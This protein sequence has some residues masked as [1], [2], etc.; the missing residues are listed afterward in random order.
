M[1]RPGRSGGRGARAQRC[2]PRAT[3]RPRASYASRLVWGP[4][5]DRLEH[6]PGRRIGQPPR[7][8]RYGDVQLVL[9]YVQ[10]SNV[11]AE[12]AEDAQHG[13]IVFEHVG[14]EGADV[15]RRGGLAQEP[16]QQGAEAAALVGVED[17]HRDLGRPRLLR[18]PDAACD[19]DRGLLGERGIESDPG[20]VVHMVDLAEL[21]KLLG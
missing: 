13:L 2:T 18:Q 19:P 20:Q 9:A 4:R 8:L 3:S 5:R 12:V 17:G 6:A 14:A 10:A 7:V 11:R 1:A 16:E 15:L 21:P